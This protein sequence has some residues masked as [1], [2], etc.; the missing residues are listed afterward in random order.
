MNRHN[1]DEIKYRKGRTLKKQ[2]M[3]SGITR[4]VFVKQSLAAAAVMAV[5]P[6][7]MAV[8]EKVMTV[9]GE[10]ESEQMGFTL[11]HEHIMSIFGGL[12]AKVAQYD[13]DKLI[14]VIDI[15]QQFFLYLNDNPTITMF[16][17]FKLQ[18]VSVF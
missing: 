1:V 2:L 3:D 8:K 7:V 11:P 9:T 15:I 13:E 17:D 6:S 5:A 12:P 18:V 16:L 14:L 10:I 4:R